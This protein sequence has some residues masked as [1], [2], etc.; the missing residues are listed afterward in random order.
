MI[1]ARSLQVAPLASSLTLAATTEATHSLSAAPARTPLRRQAAARGVPAARHRRRSR[2]C[3]IWV[4]T[5]PASPREDH[6]LDF[7]VLADFFVVD[8]AARHVFTQ[9]R[10]AGD[11]QR[12]LV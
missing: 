4:R 3:S 2:S 5:T 8:H 12:A 11:G 6:F 1:S 7:A 9:F 10:Q